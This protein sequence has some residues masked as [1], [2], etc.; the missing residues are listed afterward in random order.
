MKKKYQTTDNWLQDNKEIMN[1][2]II[3]NFE[4]WTEMF[5]FLK[6]YI[7]CHRLYRTK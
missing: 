2:Y 4:Y 7:K 6:K 3:I 1:N 5:K